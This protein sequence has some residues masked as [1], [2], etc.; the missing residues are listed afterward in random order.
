MKTGMTTYQLV[1]DFVHLQYED[2][3]FVQA[4]KQ[5]PSLLNG[6]ERLFGGIQRAI[7]ENGKAE[8]S[9]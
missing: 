9:T 4:N 7:K 8:T 3:F 2:I 6:W 5:A 1:Q